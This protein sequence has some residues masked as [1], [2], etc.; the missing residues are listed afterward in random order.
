MLGLPGGFARNFNMWGGVGWGVSTLVFMCTHRTLLVCWCVH[1]VRG[2]GWGGVC[3]RWCSC[4]HMV[5]CWCV[6]VYTWYAA[7]VL[8]CTHG[9][10]LV[11]SCVHM[12][13][14][15]CVDVYTWYVGWGGVGWGVS[16]LVFMCTHGTLLVCWC[17]HMVRCWCV[18]VYTWCAAGVFMRTH[19][20]LLVCWCVHAA[21]V[22]MVRGVGWGGVGWGVSTLVFMCTHGTL[23]VCW[24][25]HMVRCWCVDVYTWYAAGV[26]MC[27]HGALLVCSCVHMV[28]CW[29]VH[30]CTWYAAGVSC[31][32]VSCNRSVMFD[33][34]SFPHLDWVQCISSCHVSPF[35]LT[36]SVYFWCMWYIYIYMYV[37][38]MSVYICMQIV[39]NGNAV[40]YRWLLIF[41]PDL[42]KKTQV[43]T[44]SKHSMINCIWQKY[45]V[46]LWTTTFYMKKHSKI[47]TMTTRTTNGCGYSSHVVTVDLVPSR[48]NPPGGA[49]MLQS[50]FHKTIQETPLVDG[51][52]WLPPRL[53]ALSLRNAQLV[54]SRRQLN[55]GHPS[56]LGLGTS[57]D[58]L[59]DGAHFGHWHPKWWIFPHRMTIIPCHF[60]EHMITTSQPSHYECCGLGKTTPNGFI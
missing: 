32:N 33:C 55:M 36:L 12:V 14:C 17:V 38:F 53:P 48:A 24:C 50:L 26:L 9:A 15:W 19:G 35:C 21:G 11:C 43:W 56:R 1:M 52:M 7:G 54:F 23:L 60:Y 16:T 49:N 41:P 39:S 6:D 58:Q 46:Y 10:L 4:V 13:R 8:M 40:N 47:N 44:L 27:T 3:Q 42:A 31:A 22:F 37:Y 51:N 5:R 18:D 57:C 29:C 25:V 20:A 30:V 34:P 59:K 45:E 28:R 2:V